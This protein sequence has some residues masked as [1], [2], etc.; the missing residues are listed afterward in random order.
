MIFEGSMTTVNNCEA[1]RKPKWGAKAMARSGQIVLASFRELCGDTGG[2]F[3]GK[4][5]L[6][7]RRKTLPGRKVV[8][9]SSSLSGQ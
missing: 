2:V 5:F 1:L 4:Q 3:G 9:L 8:C 6:A 7:A